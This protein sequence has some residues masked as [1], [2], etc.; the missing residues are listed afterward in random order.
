MN[1]K[2]PEALRERVYQGKSTKEDAL[3]LLRYLLLNFSGLQMK[4]ALLQSET[5]SLTW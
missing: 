3:F 4:F 5:R 2:I 1:N